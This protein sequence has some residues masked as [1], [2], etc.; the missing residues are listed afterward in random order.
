M[1]RAG[2]LFVASLHR[3]R[4]EVMRTH[5][6]LDWLYRAGDHLN[7]VGHP[8]TIL[9]GA[10]VFVAVIAS[11][12]VYFSPPSL[13]PQ[14]DFGLIVGQCH[15]SFPATNKWLSVL[16]G[17]FDPKLVFEPTPLRHAPLPPP[18]HIA[19]TADWRSEM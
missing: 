4:G 5:S 11:G 6:S 18:V 8:Q 15:N 16:A 12:D 10:S 7:S 19:P 13:Y 9:R 3:T 1:V 2:M 14:S 17:E